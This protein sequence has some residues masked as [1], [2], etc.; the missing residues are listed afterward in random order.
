MLP[1]Y[2]FRLWR[3][4]VKSISTTDSGTIVGATNL[5]MLQVENNF[6]WQHVPVC[7]GIRHLWWSRQ[8]SG[9]TVCKCPI[10][11]TSRRSHH[12]WLSFIGRNIAPWCTY[13]I[14]ACRALD[15][16]NRGPFGLLVHPL[17]QHCATT[18]TFA[19]APLNSNSFKQLKCDPQDANYFSLCSF[20]R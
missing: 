7:C 5:E 20:R 10:I 2:L 1:L 8:D 9:P 18:L 19:F 3:G 17:W 14:T 11:Y 15:L 4:Y 6:C 16:K 13:V 12:C